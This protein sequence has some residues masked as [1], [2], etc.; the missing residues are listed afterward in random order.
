MNAAAATVALPAAALVIWT[1]LRSSLS[2]RFVAAPRGD[3]WHERATPLLGGVGLFA[4]LLAGVGL[5]G[6]LSTAV[7]QRTTEIGV[8]VQR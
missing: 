1:V 8:R 7:R 2:Q 4:G 3:R 5:Y 6:I